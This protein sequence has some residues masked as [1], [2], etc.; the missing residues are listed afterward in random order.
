MSQI[1]WGSLSFYT[2]V[3]RPKRTCVTFD[4]R[5]FAKAPREVAKTRCRTVAI[6]SLS[7]S[8]SMFKSLALDDCIVAEI[9]NRKLNLAESE[10]PPDL[11]SKVIAIVEAPNWNELS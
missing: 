9:N 4:Q 1:L 7:A 11:R 6:L 5:M 2:M 8:I 10:L 3:K